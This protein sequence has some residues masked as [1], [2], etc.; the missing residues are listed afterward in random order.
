MSV[1]PSASALLF[2]AGAFGVIAGAGTG[3]EK[4]VEAAQGRE[5]FA[6]VCA[7]CH[8]A[9]GSGGLPAF[10]GGPAPRNFRDHAFQEARSDGQIKLTIV[11]GKGLGMPPFGTTFTDAQL[12]ALVAQVRSFDTERK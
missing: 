4:K 1:P 9:D 6:S 2:L 5:V 7:R 12:D 10:D 11:N 3:C 8:G